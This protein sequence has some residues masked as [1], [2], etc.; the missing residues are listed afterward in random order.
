MLPTLQG[1]VEDAMYVSQ[2]GISM[3][4]EGMLITIGYVPVACAYL[5]V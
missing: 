5:T 4:T 2:G 3:T 1:L